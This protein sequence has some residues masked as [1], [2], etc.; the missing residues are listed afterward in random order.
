MMIR[1]FEPKDVDDLV[2]IH[3][4]Y[5]SEFEIEEFK[6]DFKCFFVVEDEK[7]IITMG[8]VRMIPEIVILTNKDRSTRNRITGV[9]R[10]F[11][12]IKFVSGK[13]GLNSLHCFIQDY[14]WLKILLKSGFRRTKGV[15]LIT[16]L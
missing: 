8:G 11:E 4:Q 14:D 3:Q 15:S 9:R 13:A 1:N 6:E 2:K 10:L 5:S 12:A 16:D 7:G